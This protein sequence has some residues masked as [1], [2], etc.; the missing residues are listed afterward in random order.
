MLETSGQSTCLVLKKQGIVLYLEFLHIVCDTSENWRFWILLHLSIH[1][2][3]IL[4]S[5]IKKA[6]GMKFNV[7]IRYCLMLQFL[8]S[9]EIEEKITLMLPWS[10]MYVKV[11]LTG[12]F[13]L[14]FY[15]IA[16]A[17]ACFFPSVSC[18]LMQTSL[19]PQLYNFL[20]IFLEH[21]YHAQKLEFSVKRKIDILIS[22]MAINLLSW[23]KWNYNHLT[24]SIGKFAVELISGAAR[25]NWLILVASIFNDARVRL[26]DVLWWLGCDISVRKESAP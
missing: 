3:W 24:S 11:L 17:L 19:Y 9:V 14:K 10:Q 16:V 18:R 22:N 8:R 21:K 4:S 13:A 23:I 25:M 7:M 2:W 15:M 20:L 12:R 6:L 5:K 1:F 26:D